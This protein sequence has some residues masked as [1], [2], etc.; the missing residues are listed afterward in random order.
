MILFGEIIKG[1]CCLSVKKIYCLN[2]GYSRFINLSTLFMSRNTLVLLIL[3]SLSLAIPA[4]G[5]DKDAS[6]QGA[7][8]TRGYLESQLELVLPTVA[9]APVPSPSI[10]KLQAVVTGLDMPLAIVDPDDGTNRLFIVQ[11]G[12][13]ILIFD[14][15][16]TLSAPFLDITSLVSCCNERGLLGL[17]FHPDFAS[18]GFF[19]VNYTDDNGDTVVARYSV[20][21][22]S[23]VADPDSA[24]TILT[25]NQPFSNHNGGNLVF[26]PEDYL[27]IGMGDG[28]GTG[29]PQNNAQNLGTI[30]GKM[31]RI[32]V[33]GDDFP[34]DPNRN[35][36]IPPDN[37]F[38]GVPG[39]RQEI[40]A[41][42]FRN[43]W[44]FSFDRLTGDLFLGDV[45]Q[46]DIEEIDFQSAS[47]SGGENYGWRCFE[48]NSNYNQQGCGSPIDYEFPI[49]QY[50]HSL[51]CSVT[52]GYRYRGADVADLSG[53]YIYG[54]F[55]SGRIW[56]A[57]PN[58]NG[59]WVTTQ[60]LDT[61][62]L[63]SSFGEDKSGELYVADLSGTVYKVVANVIAPTCACGGQ[64]R[65]CT[66]PGVI[67]GTGADDELNGT[68]G[69]DFICGF[70]GDD[71]IT[72]FAGSDCINGGDGDDFIRGGLGN[73]IL[74]GG[75]GN[76]DLGGGEGFDNIMGGN[77]NDTLRGWNGNDTLDGGTGVDQLIAGSGI[78]TCR[79]GESN[80][81][82]ER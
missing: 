60:L 46:G 57:V 17:A 70:G 74:I 76:D 2:N 72:G 1:F 34:N 65:S 63:I 24:F 30:L 47:S 50:T 25:A 32:D 19:Y 28:G 81:G 68:P 21:F 58:A 15:S 40:W 52:G 42:G 75:P 80:Q 45:G 14:G 66:D 71:T 13:K 79:N 8:S 5:K 38:A 26:G 10:I 43:P 49:L 44:R 29:D 7:S 39:A 22:D 69:N 18:N 61:S 9:P 41:L 73:D 20:S 4:V 6:I 3:A 53:R 11:Q 35:Y 51:G 37:P 16:S 31:L 82:C 78:D 56:G 23:N 27:Y 77:G 55:C 64:V 54:D 67:C 48:G 12:G 33:D 36:V 59:I 62:L